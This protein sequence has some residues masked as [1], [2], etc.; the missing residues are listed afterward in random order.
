MTRW[1]CLPRVL[2]GGS[3]AATVR[4]SFD[5]PR[6]TL[7][8]LRFSDATVVATHMSCIYVLQVSMAGPCVGSSEV[9]GL[10]Q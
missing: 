1:W 10:R 4:L 3:G 9:D 8:Q 7:L 2:R 6:M 5:H